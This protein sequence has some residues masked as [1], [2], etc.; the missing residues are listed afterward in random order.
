MGVIGKKGGQ[1][2]RKLPKVV[3]TGTSLMARV[4]VIGGSF[5][6]ITGALE[7]KRRLGMDHEVLLISKTDKFTFIPSLIWVPFGRRKVSDITSPVEPIVTKKGVKFLHAEATQIDP[8]KKVVKTSKGDYTY[9]YLLIA[10][11]VDIRFDAIEGLGP[12]AGYTQSVCTPGH[13]EHAK[14]A[15]EKFV[16]DPGPVVIGAVQGASCV[17]AA[18]EFLFN[19]E[20]YAR[21]RGVRKKVDVTW[22]SP[23]PFLGHFGIDGM[24]GGATMLKGFMKALRINHV[25]NAEVEK[26][27]PGKIKM[28]DG[29]VLPYKYAMLIPPFKGAKVIQNS[30]GL[31][32]EKGFIPTTDAYQHKKYP[33]IFAAGLAVQVPAPFK[34]KV[35][36]GVPKTGYPADETAK[37]AARNIAALI[38]GQGAH[39]HEKAF[40][41]IPGLCM[42]DAG[43]KEVL[44]ISNHLL[45]PRQFAIMLP[46]PFGDPSKWA[47]E[48]YFLW[49]TR[50]GMSYLP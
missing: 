27:E 28:K 24:L 43:R 49:K 38:K 34:T 37:I 31:G 45:K 44:I 33:N 22:L 39:L 4:I 25:L 20:Y 13:A 8:E 10:T 19:F 7:A 36:M 11:G 30:P 48:K 1:V 32:D 50:N 26:I 40:G 41:K 42:L 35:A 23:E 14:E 18:Y 17:G 6:G 15:F 29:K 12:D 3:L 2:F 46:N 9:D 5:A 21:K 47:F 16:K